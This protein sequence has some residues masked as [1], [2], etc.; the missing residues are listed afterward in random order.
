MKRATA[1]RR[2]GRQARCQLG[3]GCKGSLGTCSAFQNLPH[4]LRCCQ[5]SRG[6]GRAAWRPLQEVPV[7]V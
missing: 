3:T 1:I 4:C 7:N 2:P 6:S 5:M